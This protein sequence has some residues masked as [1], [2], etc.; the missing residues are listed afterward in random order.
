MP[1]HLALMIEVSRPDGSNEL[2][3][4]GSARREGP[5]YVLDVIPELVAYAP[6]AAHTDCPLCRLSERSG[7]EP[8]GNRPRRAPPAAAP[9]GGAVEELEYIAARA[10]KTLADASKSRWHAQERALLEKVE[11]ELARCRPG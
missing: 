4:V 8:A 9:G 2:V 5:R 6:R 11:A 10:R 1:A 7:G 3:R